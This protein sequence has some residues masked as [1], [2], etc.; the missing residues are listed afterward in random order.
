M[1]PVGADHA[2]E[3]VA[4]REKP[5]VLVV[6]VGVLVARAVD[7]ARDL[8]VGRSRDE[9][10]RRAFGIDDR[11]DGA[12]VIVE[13]LPHAAV[14]LRDESAALEREVGEA[15]LED[16]VLRGAVHAPAIGVVAES[17][18][19][20]AA[21]GAR[22]DPARRIVHIPHDGAISVFEFDESARIVAIGRHARRRR[23]GPAPRVDVQ[24]VPRDGHDAAL[25]IRE[26]DEPVGRVVAEADRSVIGPHFDEARLGGSAHLEHENEALRRLDDEPTVETCEHVAACRDA[27]RR[28]REHRKVHALLSEPRDHRHTACPCD[29]GLSDVAR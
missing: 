5:A 9:G 6:V 4:L 15:D 27:R 7:L 26:R 20:A 1:T 29:A 11:R 22:D 10:A 24:R 13:V 23:I 25:V 21:V 16:A 28:G 17:E 8:A 3:R 12:D 2:P 14:A 18:L 19:V